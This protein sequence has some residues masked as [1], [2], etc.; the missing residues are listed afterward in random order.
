MCSIFYYLYGQFDSLYG[1][2]DFLY[3]QR[4]N[5][6]D[7]IKSK[8]GHRN[9]EGI[10][11]GSAPYKFRLSLALFRTFEHKFCNSNIV[12]LYFGHCRR[13]IETYVKTLKVKTGK[14]SL[15]AFCNHL[16]AKKFA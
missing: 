7:L 15:R 14:R 8:L 1:Q 12:Y 3:D 6:I 5:R 13:V 11:T 10:F 4:G 2:L 16:D 9:T